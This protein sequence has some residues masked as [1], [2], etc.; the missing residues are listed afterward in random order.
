LNTPPEITRKSIAIY[1]YT[2]KPA[3]DEAYDDQ[4]DWRDAKK[5]TSFGA[6]LRSRFRR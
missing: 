3:S 4:I 5:H 1:Y 6:W 2:A